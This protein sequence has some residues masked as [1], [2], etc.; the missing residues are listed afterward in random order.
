MYKCIYIYIIH[1]LYI[2]K[3]I[4]TNLI[5]NS[6]IFFQILGEVYGF[7]RSSC[8]C[9]LKFFAHLI[10]VDLPFSIFKHLAPYKA[11]MMEH[12]ATTLNRF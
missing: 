5:A 12:F 7:L 2:Y 6:V 3:C 4:Y 9:S 8:L 1:I 10:F 11:S